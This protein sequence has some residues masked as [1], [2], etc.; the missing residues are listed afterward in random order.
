MSPTSQERARLDRGATSRFGQ[1]EGHNAGTGSLDDPLRAP[2]QGKIKVTARV[3]KRRK[4]LRSQ[5]LRLVQ[6]RLQAAGLRWL[7]RRRKTLVPEQSVEARK[8]WAR[9]VLRQPRTVLRRFVYVDGVS[10]YLDKSNEAHQNTKRLALGGYVWRTTERREALFAD[11][12]GPS[13][14]IKA[15]GDLVR[16]WGML[17]QGRL[18][19]A[20]FNKG[21]A[22]NRW[23]YDRLIRSSFPTWLRG[24]RRPLVV[25][26]FERCLRCPEP[27]AAFKDIGAAVLKHHPKHSQDLNAVENVWALLRERLNDTMPQRREVRASFLARLRRAVAWLNTAHRPALLALGRDQKER[28]RAVLGRSGERPASVSGGG[29]LSKMLRQKR[30]EKRPR[31]EQHCSCRPSVTTTPFQLL[32]SGSTTPLK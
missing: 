26:D 7:R 23:E 13:S 2:E 32:L 5:S 15:Q 6:R 4:K 12:V 11:C 8:A 22:M 17:T 27:L 20:V 16:V 28:A 31:R 21:A 10:F 1:A 14:Y 25:Q 9:W 18:H 3:V 30:Q 29:V 19:I 24:L